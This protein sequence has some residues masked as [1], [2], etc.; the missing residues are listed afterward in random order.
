MTKLFNQK[1]NLQF[2]ASFDPYKIQFE[3]DSNV[4]TRINKVGAFRLTDYSVNFGYNF[5]NK[6]FGDG[7]DSKK[8]DRRGEVR[9]ENFYFDEYD[10]AHFSI[11]WR[12]GLNFTHNYSRGNLRK[13]INTT[14]VAINASISPTPYWSLST[15][16][17]YDF[18]AK[19]L[20]EARISFNRDL[21]SFNINFSWVPFGRYKTWDF[22]IGIK[23]DILKDAVKYDSKASTLLRGGDF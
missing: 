4:G 21:R 15:S 19:K 3:D 12:L 23:A 18:T 9:D 11:P 13:G 8:Y 2:R 10:Y 16:T 20:S 7:F 1:L 14:V 22:F 6:T 5:D 17:S